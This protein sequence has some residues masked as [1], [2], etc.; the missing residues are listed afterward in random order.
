MC[1]G[2]FTLDHGMLQLRAFTRDA[3]GKH[4]RPSA[5]ATFFIDFNAVMPSGT[6][7]SHRLSVPRPAA[8][9]RSANSEIVI[10]AVPSPSP[11][12]PDPDT[13]S[14]G[15][16]RSAGPP[17]VL[18]P[19]HGVHQFRVQPALLGSSSVRRPVPVKQIAP[20]IAIFVESDL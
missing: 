19:L 7:D 8:R 15:S 5:A 4:S 10:A 6:R 18:P 17:R 14:I 9:P 12:H 11:P 13:V 3:A 1:D 20:S 16:Q 2:P